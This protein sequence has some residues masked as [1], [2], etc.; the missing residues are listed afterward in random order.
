ME[1]Q[2]DKHFAA[3]GRGAGYMLKGRVSMLGGCTCVLGSD[4]MQE[5]TTTPLPLRL[6]KP[7]LH[8]ITGSLC[9]SFPLIWKIQHA[10]EGRDLHYLTEAAWF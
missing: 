6:F 3:G 9:S 2:M 1:D 5:N 8:N 10:R 4:C 7:A